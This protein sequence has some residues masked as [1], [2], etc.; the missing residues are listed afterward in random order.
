MG[1]SLRANMVDSK[2]ALSNEAAV[3]EQPRE[4]ALP[5]LTSTELR[6]MRRMYWWRPA[7]RVP[8]VR[9][10]HSFN[11]IYDLKVPFEDGAPH[12]LIKQAVLHFMT[13]KA[14]DDLPPGVTN[15]GRLFQRLQMHVER[16]EPNNILILIL[17]G[18]KW[19]DVCSY[20]LSDSGDG[21][22]HCAVHFFSAGL[23]PLWLPFAVFQSVML[24]SI[25][26]GGKGWTWAKDLHTLIEHYMSLTEA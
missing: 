12:V 23:S 4:T 22:T 19:V 8:G 6:R 20:S 10:N 15:L 26:F 7:V 5:S 11:Y 9:F 16:C 2:E 21:T 13:R 3:T 1:G 17:T 18:G 25:P 24:W 14:I